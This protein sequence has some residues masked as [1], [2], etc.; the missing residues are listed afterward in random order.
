MKQLLKYDFA[1]GMYVPSDVVA[2]ESTTD[3]SLRKAFDT[4]FAKVIFDNRLLTRIR[5][6]NHDVFSRPN[7]IEW[8]GSCLLGVHPIR[9]LPQDTN[10]FFDDVLGVD[11]DQLAEAIRS[12]KAVNMDWNV[13]GNVMNLA[14]TYCVHR[15]IDKKDQISHDIGYELLMMMQFKFYTSIYFNNFTK[16]GRL[17]D[18]PT[19]EATYAALSLRFEIKQVGSWRAHLAARAEDFL[20]PTATTHY[21]DMV[22]FDN[23]VKIIYFISDLN[24]R[25]KN[26]VKDY[27]GVLKNTRANGSRILVQSATVILDGQSIIRDRVTAFNT[28]KQTL[29]DASASFS[30]FYK[31][32]LASVVLEMV[33]KA[34]PTAFKAIIQYMANL[35]MGKARDEVNG[36]M[37]DVISHAF[38]YVVSKRINF[39]DVGFFLERMRA[40]Y[41]APKSSNEYVLSLRE[42]IEKLV[43]RETH[44]THDAAL[45]ALRN[46]LM[47]YF[48]I[49][50]IAG[51]V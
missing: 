10:R 42:R 36:I 12:T 25:A 18:I 26:T 20:S 30:S 40:L 50:A 13:G 27:Y 39:T 46:V 34:S 29:F 28:A 15:I 11:E 5:A 33:P 47:L 41:Q 22:K 32:E 37:E 51:T 4:A 3:I 6:L 16:K 23:P 2:T 35:P 8:F 17:V 38:D 43:K 14:I 49:R 19:A 24:T 31:V 44:L 7:N 48:L 21:Q 9:W 1:A 45:A